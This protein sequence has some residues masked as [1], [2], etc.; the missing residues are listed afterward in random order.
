MRLWHYDLLDVLPSMQLRGQWRECCAIAANISEQGSPNHILVNRIMDFHMKH[1]YCYGFLVAEQMRK[2]GY[3]CDFDKFDQYFT[4]PHEKHMV[5]M[6]DLFEGWHNERYLRQCYYNLEE[7]FD[8]G[9][10]RQEDWRKVHDRFISI[11]E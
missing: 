4:Y 10:I 7:K 8:C 1:F 11:I 3:K 9:G 6:Y 5:P 2:R